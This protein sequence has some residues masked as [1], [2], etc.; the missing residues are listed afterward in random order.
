MSEV[1]DNEWLAESCNKLEAIGLIDHLG[2]SVTKS[3][4]LTLLG[5]PEGDVAA[6]W[7]LDKGALSAE[8]V[9]NSEAS[10]VMTI[11]WN[12]GLAVFSGSLAPAVVYMQGKFK[13]GG[14]MELL[15]DLL[16]FERTARTS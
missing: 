11:P 13:G 14:D 15:L 16:A 7:T 8:P 6:T 5:G 4:S 3:F 1:F 12:E 2:V 9:L 10:V